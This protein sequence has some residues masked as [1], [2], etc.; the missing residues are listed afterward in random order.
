MEFTLFYQGTLKS[1]GS[2]EHKQSIRREFHKQLMAIWDQGIFP[3]LKR[4]LIKRNIINRWKIGNFNFLPLVNGL[5]RQLAQLD[6]FILW[7]DAPGSIVLNKGDIDNRLKTLLD[8]LRVPQNI[9]EI[10]KGDSPAIDENFFYCLLEDDKLITKITVA[11]VNTGKG[12]AKQT[13]NICPKIFL[14]EKR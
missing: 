8:A 3:E 6:I 9:Q 12:V 5:Y 2:K 11:T 10:P 14:K 7:P 13:W 1:N 4:D